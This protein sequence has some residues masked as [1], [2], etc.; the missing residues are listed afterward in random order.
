MDSLRRLLPFLKPYRRRI[1]VSFLFGL[2]VAVLWGGNIT[3]IFPVFSTLLNR[4]PIHDYVA[5]AAVDAE[6]EIAH[7]EENLRDIE[8]RV[9]AYD[10]EHLP[11]QDP[12]RMTQ[13][14]RRVDT[15]ARLNNA[16]RQL[17]LFRRVEAHVLPW[18]PRDEFKA[19]GVILIVLMIAEVV[20]GIF[21]YYQEV[22]IGSVIQRVVMAIRT[23]CLEKILQLD[24][25]TLARDG[26]SE[27]MSRFTYDTEQ[28]T[29]GLMLVGTRALREPLKCLACFALAM[30]VNWRLSLLSVFSLPL[31]ALFLQWYG[32]VLKRASRRVMDSMTRIYKVLEETLEGLRIVISFDAA[33]RHHARFHRE[34]N[35]FYSKAM[36]VVKIDAFAKPTMEV[37]GLLAMFVAM[38]PGAYLVLQQKTD[39]WGV[40]LTNDVMSAA[41]LCTLYALLLGMLDPCRRMSATFS[42]MKRCSA[43]LDRIFELVDRQPHVREMDNAVALPRL[44]QSIEFQDI[45]FQYLA[46]HAADARGPALSGVNLTVKAGEVVALVGPNGCGKSTLVSMLPR[47]YDPTQGTILFDGVN[48]SEARLGDLRGQLGLVTQETMLFDDTI[49]E[50]IRYGKP[51]ATAAEVADAARRAH[52]AEFAKNLPQGLDTPVGERGKELSGGQRQRVALARAI[53]RDPAVLILDEATSAADAQSEAFILQ[54]LDEFVVGRTVFVITHSMTPSLLKLVDRIVVMQSGAI[55][56]HGTH[57]ELLRTCAIYESL[58]RAKSFAKA[59]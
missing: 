35:H 28:V 30:W 9:A 47:L 13:L 15:E 14:A 46:R 41:G 43:A 39:I 24:Y 12:K 42:R 50:N 44:A 33:D 17:L 5:K 34:N 23:Q 11:P 7:Q 20:K 57:D 3:A 29:Q 59:A 40:R 52:V 6:K 10:A 27:L 25:Q 55:V 8:Q 18:V 38:L 51:N 1:V 21:T 19:F 48:I 16:S 37:L 45:S 36:R 32:H 2:V 49:A 26:T 56:G 58:Y 4:Q 22:L 54:A 31:L 53:V